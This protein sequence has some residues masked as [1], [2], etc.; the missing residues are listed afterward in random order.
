MENTL[1][2]YFLAKKGIHPIDV[3]CCTDMVQNKLK[4][5][6]EMI[7]G[8]RK[9]CSKGTKEVQFLWWSGWWWRTEAIHGEAGY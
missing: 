8:E 4:C 2:E 6:N 9:F 7:R 5:V 3:L 1:R